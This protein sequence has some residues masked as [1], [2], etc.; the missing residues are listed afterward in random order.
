MNQ[1]VRSIF[2][3]CFLQ[4]HPAD[5]TVP[6]PLAPSHQVCLQ[7]QGT[8]YRDRV[9]AWNIAATQALQKYTQLSVTVLKQEPADT[10]WN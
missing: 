2:K 1:R 6:T 7:S 4:F 9:G 10:E 8:A 3:G 5:Y